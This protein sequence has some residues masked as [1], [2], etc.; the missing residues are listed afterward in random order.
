V[1]VDH[2]LQPG[3][4]AVAA[5]TA[6][7]LTAQG[8]DPVH[9]VAVVVDDGGGPEDAARNARYR[10]L[11]EVAD[12]TGAVAVL[13]GHTREDQAETVLLGLA[14][15][16]GARS[17]AGMASVRGRYRR[18]LLALSRATVHA[19]VPPEAPVWSDPHNL[20]PA[21]LRVRVRHELLP[22][23][24]EV[25]GPG[26]DAALAR[27]ADLLRADADALDALAEQAYR[28]LGGSAADLDVAALV[29]LPPAV[30]SRVLRRAAIAAGCPAADLGADHVAA[31]VELI[32]DWHGQGSPALPGGVR[33]VRRCGRLSLRTP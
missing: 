32:S 18:P 25:L 8:L 1:I 19:A 4:A 2:G 31:L 22:A 13:L 16:S 17:L 7:W 10:A 9:V 28:D 15:G 3:S 24:R 11:D 29:D 20:D 5:S 12:R 30:L 26:V 6:D 14:R 33:A 27:T 23:L 21:Y